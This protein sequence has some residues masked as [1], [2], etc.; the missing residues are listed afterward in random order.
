MVL[1]EDQKGKNLRHKLTCPEVSSQGNVSAP[2]PEMT[3]HQPQREDA[4]RQ[5]LQLLRGTTLQATTM[6]LRFRGCQVPRYHLPLPQL[7]APT[8]KALLSPQMKCSHLVLPWRAQ[9]LFSTEQ[10]DAFTPKYRGPAEIQTGDSQVSRV[11]LGTLKGYCPRRKV[12][13]AP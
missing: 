7:C 3:E 9:D 8:L 4:G 13:F 5:R 1:P 2:A 11:P 6:G 12:V 10:K